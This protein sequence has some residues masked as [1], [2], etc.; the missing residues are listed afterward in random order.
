MNISASVINAIVTIP[1]LGSLMRDEAGNQIRKGESL[2]VHILAVLPGWNHR[3]VLPEA[4]LVGATT[5]TGYSSAAFSR[6][7]KII[8]PEGHQL[9]AILVDSDGKATSWESLPIEIE[10]GDANANQAASLTKIIS[11]HLTKELQSGGLLH[12][13]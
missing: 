8:L 3:S 12:K 1:S 13:R 9:I 5:F 6:S 10:S 11:Q 4:L 2:R 7:V